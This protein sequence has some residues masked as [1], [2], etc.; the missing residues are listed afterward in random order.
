MYILFKSKLK[1]GH[2][3]INKKEYEEKIKLKKNISR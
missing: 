3:V 1:P 2:F